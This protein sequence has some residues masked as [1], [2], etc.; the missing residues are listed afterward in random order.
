MSA[1]LTDSAVYGHLWGTDETRAMLSDEGRLRA[2][3][4]LL[5]VLAQAQA[6]AGLVP[7]E[8]ADSIVEAVEGWLPDPVEVGA[9]TR[10][11]G[12][13]TLGL[14]RVLE[15][16]L[17]ERAREW[18]YYGAT[19]QD[20][21]DTW[22]VLVMRQMTAIVLRDL[23][24]ARAAA[25][26]LVRAHRSTL[27]CGRTHGQPGL[28]ITFGFKAAMWADELDRHIRRLEASRAER[29]VVQ[30][31][32]GL[33]SME[34]WGEAAEPMI[35]SFALRLDLGVAPLPWLTARDRFAEFI[36]QLAMVAATIAKIGDEVYELQRAEIGELREPLAAGTVGSITMPHKRNP[37]WAE[38][39]STLARLVRVN[40]DLAIE[41]MIHGHERDGRAWKTEWVVLPEVCH[42]TAVSTMAAV[43][44]LDGLEVDSARMRANLD[45]QRGYVLSEPVMR[46]LAD[47]V[48]KHTAHRIVYEAA[49][50]GSERGVDLRTALRDDGR[51][52]DISDVELD[53]LL[54]PALAL[55]S[56]PRFIDA[57]LQRLDG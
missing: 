2:W 37:E 7:R 28:P 14:I 27:M 44:I 57:L 19:V 29:E 38:H 5:A 10:A 53:T 20:L 24:V 34:F 16:R 12:H 18:V 50:S 52:T 33:G 8:A 47:R 25:V 6:D 49:L 32:G 3:L 54:D 17:P 41:G 22:S 26:Q 9:L 42:F 13:S 23:A 55:G 43:R 21:S 46:A 56:I 11:T 40:A 36:T 15:Q 48:G 51:L 1:H 45:A 30:L 4:D 35:D 31:G 39:V